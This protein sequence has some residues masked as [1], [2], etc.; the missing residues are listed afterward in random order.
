VNL[1]DK[2]IL[3]RLGAGI[4][5]EN[6]CETA[7]CLRN[8]FDRW[9]L[10]SAQRRVPSLDG[11]VRAP[12]LSDVQID[13]DPWGI[14]HIYAENDS[15]LFVAFGYAMAQDRLFQ[16]DYLRRKGAGRLAEI[17]GSEALSSDLLVRTVGLPH[18]ARAEW[19]RLPEETQQ[20]L[21]S[22]TAG[23]NALIEQ[24]KDHLPIEFD[25][26]DYE[27]EPWTVF[28]CLTIESE[29][30]WYL[31]GRFPVIVIPELAKRGLDDGALYEE[32]MCGEAM[33]E[34]ILPPEGYPPSPSG[35]AAESIGPSMGGFDDGTGS[36]NWVVGGRLTRSGKPL[37]ASDPH[38]AI[39]AVS[40]WHQAHLCGGSFNVA[41]MSYVGMPAIMFG[42]NE[43]VGWGI[44]NNICSLRDLYQEKTS[45]DH[46]GCFLFDSEWEPYRERTETVRVR[47]Q[48]PV[49]KTIR[50]SRNGPIV[51]DLLPPPA[52]TTGPVSLRWLGMHEGGWLTALLGIDRAR[53]VRGFEE[54][55]R[56]WHVPTFSLVFADRAGHTGLK[57][58]GRIPI[59]N[60]EEHG[61]R[62][63]WELDHQ[64][65][66]LIPFEDMPGV[67]DPEQG[68]AATANNPLATA[69]Y[70]YPLS[71][72][73]GAGYRARR[74]RQMITEP[75]R[76]LHSP[77]TFGHM[78]VDAVSLRALNCLP[79]ILSILD[80]HA[81]D[82]ARAADDE[83]RRQATEALR[84][85]D[86]EVLPDAIGPTI[87]NVFFRYWTRAVV[88][89]RFE[90]NAQPLLTAG[91]EALAARLLSEDRCSWF[92]NRD[93]DAH[94][95]L[96]F[97][98][99]LEDL[100]Q[101]FGSDMTTWGW[102]KLHRLTMDH[103]LSSRGDL[104]QLFNY[105]G[106]GVRGDIQCVGNTG[107]GPD[108]E[109]Q[110]G[111]GF[112]MIADLSD[113]A[114]LL[115]VDAPSQ[116]G[117]VGSTHYKDQLA[118]WLSGDYHELPLHRERTTVRYQQTLQPDDQT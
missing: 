116:S 35:R 68:F 72:T 53:D 34:C 70:P 78:Q 9:W 22:F 98:H 88:A 82:D 25:L 109:A 81:V 90:E 43:D 112:R 40:C 29:F 24:S 108:W 96:A 38:I 99:T 19:T 28:D 107:G 95:I 77:A 103:V 97:D 7:G 79:L 115:T 2:Q 49:T 41:G 94:V 93:R 105:A 48:D 64:W 50:V 91:A 52:D 113:A 39:E 73:S 5:I 1:T 47:D 42:R 46:P 57:I 100:T 84:D 76:S 111:G 20:L 66:G 51:D 92:A 10:T 17:L 118:D 74:V 15:D 106:M 45:P 18:I 117:H 102:G 12:V 56:P 89:E 36:N 110:A 16:L 14:P 54:A 26:L 37:V 86:G 6:L 61:Y 32:F 27:P 63:G 59:R 33:D 31:T 67:I 58:S 114:T 87:F 23:I 65:S 11:E 75:D 60:V 69:D 3:K 4:S 85:W 104:D 8:D 80:T 55:L 30:R 62:P 83:R 101:R 44:T 13:R 71:C 21:T